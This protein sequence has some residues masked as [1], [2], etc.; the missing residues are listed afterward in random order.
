MPAVL[1]PQQKFSVNFSGHA[2]QPSRDKAFFKSIEEL[3]YQVYCE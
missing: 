3:R 1:Q 2:V